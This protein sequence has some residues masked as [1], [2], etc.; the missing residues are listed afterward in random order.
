MGSGAFK[1]VYLGI[2]HERG[3]EVAW[4]QLRISQSQKYLQE[5]QLLQT[6]QHANI[7]KFYKSWID[8]DGTIVFI[9]EWMSTG[10]L[11]Q[12]E[13]FKNLIS[14]FKNIHKTKN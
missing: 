9:T 5:I 6:F 14:L 4:N 10:T 2:D 7:I 12:L 1:I 8:K 13:N 11:K 3:I